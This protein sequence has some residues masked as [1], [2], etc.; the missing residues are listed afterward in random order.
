VTTRP[1]GTSIT[2]SGAGLLLI[3]AVQYVHFIG[4][5]PSGWCLSGTALLA[6]LVL[7]HQ[8]ASVYRLRRDFAN[9]HRGIMGLISLEGGTPRTRYTYEEPHA[10][11]TELS[12]A[13]KELRNR[14]IQLT[15][16]ASR[17]PLTGLA[18]RRFLVD[19]LVR[20]VAAAE[21]TRWPV[22]LVMVDLDHFK[23]LNDT[24]GH[25][26]GDVVLRRTAERLSSLVRDADLVARFGGEEFA[27]VLPR[28]S[29][30]KAVKL[31]QELRN[32]L[33]CTML[34]FEDQQIQVTASFG[35]AE[36]HVC[37]LKDE[38]ELVREADAALYEA[39]ASGRDRVVAAP[40]ASTDEGLERRLDVAS[41]SLTPMAAPSGRS[42]V[43]PE[44][45]A[46][47]GTM[48]SL[49]EAIPD[50]HRVAHDT[51]QQ[52]ATVLACER[53][54]LFLQRRGHRG[55]EPIAS[56]GI[57]PHEA[58]SGMLGSPELLAWFTDL[59]G[60]RGLHIEASVD[61]AV[62]ML[63]Q[64]GLDR[65]T[66]R[67]PVVAGGNL[68]GALEASDVPNGSQ[69]GKR[70]RS[71]LSAV[72]LIGGTA[73]TICDSFRGLDDIW[74]AMVEA[75][76]GMMQA[77]NS[78]K[79]D[80]AARVSNLAVKIAQQLGQTDEEELRLLRLAGLLGDVGAASIPQQVWQKKGRLSKRQR[81]MIQELPWKGAEIIQQF[82][83]MDQ[84]ARIVLHHHEHFD[85]SGYPDGL[86]GEDIPFECRILAVAEA[87]VAMTSIR[88]YRAAM[89]DRE[90]I[91]E[92]VAKR[93]SQF[94]PV[95]ADALR[96]CGVK[97]ADAYSYDWSVDLSEA[98][99]IE[100]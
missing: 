75:L 36:L 77:Q 83:E 85:G 78:F 96:E 42:T 34:E 13:A 48:F 50:L 39:K 5:V 33:R 100:A 30:S 54:V 72:C 32:A 14:R 15:D 61:V 24:H 67:I 63:D 73:I 29:L 22:S 38:E 99:V 92:I 89:S 69:L 52:F 35:V 20:E 6:L 79:K 21:R 1:I 84:L 40:R 11:A 19:T 74:T 3:A 31:A 9:L 46:L 59:R 56:V 2:V 57:A 51:V 4:L 55:L 58:E 7:L 68:I 90:A 80:H 10:C 18:N 70:Q 98:T 49:L 64:E 43:D 62:T 25:Q 91:K 88:P 86:V 87:Y 23:D 37:G 93:G 81:A 47:M 12:N 28:A 45:M 44:T 66:V 8:C 26:C 16:T 60:T 82:S 71:L 76:C 97:R 65:A 41:S 27:I 17:D 94:D 53:A 95:V